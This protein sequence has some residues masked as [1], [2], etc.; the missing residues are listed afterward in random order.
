MMNMVISPIHVSIL[1]EIASSNLGV[2]FNILAA[3]LRGKV[4]RVTLSREIKKLINLSLIEVTP[5]PSHK[6]RLIYRIRDEV[7]ELIDDLRVPARSDIDQI[8]ADMEKSLKYY[9]MKIKH[10]KNEALKDYMR[11]LILSSLRESLMLLE[12]ESNG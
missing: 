11:H 7:R 12:G 2:S 9:T 1:D 3:R 5:D 10:V 4:S 6:Q 8:L